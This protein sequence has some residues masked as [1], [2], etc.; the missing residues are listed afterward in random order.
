MLLERAHAD[1][2]CVRTQAADI[3]KTQRKRQKPLRVSAFQCRFRGGTAWCSVALPRSITNLLRRGRSCLLVRSL[4]VGRLLVRCLVSG[5]SSCRSRCFR[6]RSL[7]KC[8]RC[9]QASDESS[10]QFVHVVNPQL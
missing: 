10:D 5:R 3:S 6:G 4:L 9:E 8:S 1:K 7:C 2:K